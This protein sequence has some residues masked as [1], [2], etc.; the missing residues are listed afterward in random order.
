MTFLIYGSRGQLIRWQG[1][2]EE[3]LQYAK[4]VNLWNNIGLTDVPSRA[5]LGPEA[6]SAWRNSTVAVLHFVVVGPGEGGH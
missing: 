5:S 3:R 2:S 1:V 4:D 6:K